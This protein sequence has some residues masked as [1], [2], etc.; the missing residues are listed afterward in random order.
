MDAG[1]DG[2][3]A[4]G[5]RDDGGGWGADGWIGEGI[6]EEEV[7]ERLAGWRNGGMMNGGWKDNRSMG[8]CLALPYRRADIQ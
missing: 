1:T 4:E 7:G 6:I 3:W 8:K 2:E 5:W